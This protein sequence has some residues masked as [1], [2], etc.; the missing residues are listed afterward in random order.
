M[1]R[2]LAYGVRTSLNT[3][4]VQVGI[5]GQAASYKCLTPVK[6][7]KQ[8]RLAGKASQLS[9]QTTCKNKPGDDVLLAFTIC[10]FALI[11]NQHKHTFCDESFDSEEI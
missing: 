1:R 11:L 2:A 7:A 6:P 9:L 5:Y 8:Q 4:T 3:R 10:T